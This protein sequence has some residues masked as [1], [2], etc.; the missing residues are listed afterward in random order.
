MQ[1]RKY[2]FGFVAIRFSS[3]SFDPLLL[4]LW[5]LLCL[6]KLAVRLKLDVRR[7]VGVV[8]LALVQAR[9]VVSSK[10]VRKLGLNGRVPGGQVQ[11]RGLALA[12]DQLQDSSLG[13]L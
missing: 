3:V 2:F 7:R 5:L 11:D 12:A 8:G 13:R 6:E 1:R 9:E 10:H 4:L